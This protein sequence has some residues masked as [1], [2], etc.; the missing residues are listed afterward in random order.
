MAEMQPGDAGA[1]VAAEAVV[2]K[3]KG[4]SGVWI[5]PIVA[6][7]VGLFLVWK[8]FTEEGPTISL[9]F[10]SAAGITVGKTKVRFRAVDVGLVEDIEISENLQ[11]VVLSVKMD[12]GAAP[13]LRD[14]TKFWVVKPRIVAGEI[15]GLDTLTKGAYIAMEPSETGAKRRKFRG[16]ERPPLVTAGDAGSF[17]RLRADS[18]GGL[19][20]GSPVFFRQIEV[21]RVT[22]VELDESGEFVNFT[23]FVDAPHHHRITRATRFWNAGGVDFTLD[24]NGVQIETTSF[25][26]M[27]LGGIEFDT[28]VTMTEAQAADEDFV[29]RLYSSQRDSQ[30]QRFEV[31]EYYLVYFTENVRG[32]VPGAP[33]EF[34]GLKIGEVLDVRLVFDLSTQDVE[35]PVLLEIEP[36]RIVGASLEPDDPEGLR[37][38]VLHGLRA[39]LKAGNLLTGRRVIDFDFYPDAPEANVDFSQ[40]YPV[41]PVMPSPLAGIAEGMASIVGKLNEM[42]LEEIGKNLETASA[43]LGDAVGDGQLADSIER[44]AVVLANLEQVSADFKGEIT[45]QMA[46]TLRETQMTMEELRRGLAAGSPLRQEMRRLLVEMA[47]AA[48]SIRLL[49]DYLERNPESLVFGKKRENQE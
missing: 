23:V 31:K 34:R 43:G 42:P 22:D 21:G 37:E 7:L 28:P 44:M 19:G 49:T 11:S 25:V 5:V 16:L 41:L 14:D 18:K 3:K 47:D 26:T 12:K 4:I 29:F 45:P 10:N 36:E 27:L 24:A 1:P 39:R 15:Q 13:F 35:V 48:Q 20:L 46:E 33:V 6:G 17:F 2:E 32:L 9:T 8:T 40:Q 38:A 30:R